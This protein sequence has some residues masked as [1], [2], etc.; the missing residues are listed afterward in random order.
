ML[1]DKDRTRLLHMRD[2][3]R[4][5]IAL[6]AGRTR[7]DLD[8]DRLLNLSLVRLLE[9]VGEAA[10]RTSDTARSLCPQV[11]WPQIAALRNRL[12]HGYDSVDFDILWTILQ[13]ELPPLVEQ[14]E[15]LL[16][17]E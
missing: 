11:P 17:H 14:V 6:V 13:K 7:E 3:G 8:R 1:P 16:E 9:I 15:H 10:A 12:I 5:A 4:E 2:H